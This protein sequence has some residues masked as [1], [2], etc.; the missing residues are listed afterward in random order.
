[1]GGVVHA[2]RGLKDIAIDTGTFAL[3]TAV[4]LGIGAVAGHSSSSVGTGGGALIGAAVGA[5]IGIAILMA[6]KG[7]RVDVHPGDEL[8][9]ELA[10]R[11]AYAKYVAL[12]NK[13]HKRRTAHNL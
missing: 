1:M 10:R 9:I 4:A 12:N 3:P 2:R 7:K 5:A 11:L 13:A 6:K 8:K